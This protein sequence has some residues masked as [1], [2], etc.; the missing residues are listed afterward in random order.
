MH[1]TLHN[2]VNPLQQNAIGG[3]SAARVRT[4]QK[5]SENRGDTGLLPLF[6]KE[7]V[8]SNQSQGLREMLSRD[9]LREATGVKQHS[10]RALQTTETLKGMLK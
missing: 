1:A 5:D 10:A 4:V 6:V 9:Q 8:M 3:Q 7:D 2:L